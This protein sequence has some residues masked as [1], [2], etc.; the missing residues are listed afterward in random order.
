MDINKLKLVKPT[1]ELET[2]F[3]EM[4][5]E[6][7]S[8][9]ERPRPG[10][11][12]IE[13]DY[14][15]LITKLNNYSLGIR[16]EEKYVPNSTY[17]LLDHNT[18]IGTVNIRHYLNEYLFKYDGHI[19][20]AIRPRQRN[21]GYGTIMLCLAL[22]KARELD[23]EKALVT[24]NKGN[25]ASEKIIIKNGGIFDSEEIEGNGN[26]VRRFWINLK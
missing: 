8:F 11:I 19:G 10:I 3:L 14:Q 6:F 26:I 23:I 21:N 13:T 22:D 2:A 9:N 20:G 12:R 24:C 15:T 25:L 18:I 5:A 17:V 16:I 4:L 7:K 1:L